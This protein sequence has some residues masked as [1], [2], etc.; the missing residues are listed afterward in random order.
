MLES[1]KE[2]LPNNCIAKRCIFLSIPNKLF[3]IITL[4]ILLFSPKIYEAIIRICSDMAGFD[5]IHKLLGTSS[6][7]FPIL[8]KNITF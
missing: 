7:V 2:T 4:P 5:P 3:F 6:E 8:E 1:I